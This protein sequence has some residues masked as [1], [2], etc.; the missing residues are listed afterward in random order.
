MARRIWII[1][2]V[3]ACSNHAAAQ[4]EQS[5]TLS[6]E[7]IGGVATAP[8]YSDNLPEAAGHGGV[9]VLGGS[10]RATR[11]L[12]LGLSLP[13]VSIN[14]RQPAG[15]YVNE[16]AWGNPLLWAE[17]RW[18][19]DRFQTWLRFGV[20]A[21]LA[22]HGP[23]RLLY[24]NRA[25]VIADA[26][27]GWQDR[28]LFAAGFVPAPLTLGAA[29]EHGIFRFDSSLELVPMLRLH[30]ASLAPEK[31]NDFAFSGI[32]AAG[33]FVNPL[34]WFGAGLHAHLV[35]DAAP[36]ADSPNQETLQP[37]LRPELE[38]RI[39]EHV[40]LRTD[41]FVPIAGS[42]GGDTVGV[43]VDTNVTW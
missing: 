10:W 30:D 28:E 8:F 42:L 16:A 41:V 27:S 34:A 21:P 35:V 24:E 20:G 38:F 32:L 40:A 33:G 12:S 11:G 26:I 15:S 1:A 23:D 5:I 14:V 17:Q 31:T 37:V 4:P 36:Q 13:A 39:G 19:F 25:L 7:V 9:F 2:L 43:G 6:A 29:Y 3:V 22:E 18:T